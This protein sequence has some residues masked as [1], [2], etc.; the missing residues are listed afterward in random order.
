M[1]RIPLPVRYLIGVMTILAATLGLFSWL[2]RPA[3][4]DILLTALFLAVT[5]GLS[6]VAGYCAYRLGWL[7]RSPKLRLTLLG[8]YALAGLL[9][10]FNVWVTARLMF[11][12]EHDLQLATVLLLFAGGIAM[13]LGFFVS[14]TLSGRIRRLDS[15][16]RMLSQG[17]L[18]IRVPVE[19]R[20]EIADLARSFNQMATRLEEVDRQKRELDQLRRDLV[21]WASHDL[22]TPLTAIQVQVEAIADGLVQDAGSTQRYLRSIQREA[23]NLSLLIDDLFQVAQMDAGGLILECAFYPMSDLISDTLESFSAVAV[24]RGVQLSGGIAS[25]LDPVRLDAQ[26]I[27]RALNNLISNALRHTPCGGCVTVTAK[28]IPGAVQVEVED[29]GEG[30]SQDDLPHVFDRFYRGEKSRNRS[31]GGAGLGL[32]IARGIVEAHGGR[33]AVR[34]QAGRGTVFTLTIPG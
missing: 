5:A 10:F 13:V 33:I 9:T 27:G 19:G 11:V 6:G 3:V 31:S 1:N 24:G 2:M 15:A 14:T 30:I 23:H 34:S 22:Q 7:E 26:R 18:T 29:T 21:A 32:A 17:D 25:D 12:S 20:D 28:R 4:P 8:T 16:A